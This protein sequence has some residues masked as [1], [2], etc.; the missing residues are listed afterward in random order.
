MDYPDYYSSYETTTKDHELY[1]GEYDY[2]PYSSNDVD[3]FYNDNH[4]ELNEYESEETSSHF[5]MRPIYNFPK[6]KRKHH[7]R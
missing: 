5:S 4:K 3:Y 7:F 2:F 1:D 6:P